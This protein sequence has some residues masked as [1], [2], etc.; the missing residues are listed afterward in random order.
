MSM[1]FLKVVAVLVVVVI[2][3]WFSTVFTAVVCCGKTNIDSTSLGDRNLGNNEAIEVR[4]LGVL[5]AE[6]G[7]REEVVSEDRADIIANGEASSR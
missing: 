5:G 2:S 3:W 7:E 4:L 1:V 6:I